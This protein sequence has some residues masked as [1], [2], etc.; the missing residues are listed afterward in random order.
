[1]N[2]AVINAKLTIESA[3]RQAQ[4]KEGK[5]GETVL[6]ISQKVDAI[7]Q[8]IDKALDDAPTQSKV[9]VNVSDADWRKINKQF[10]KQ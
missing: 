10:A 4:P 1:M 9:S 8:H 5:L 2:I 6:G 7:N 3:I